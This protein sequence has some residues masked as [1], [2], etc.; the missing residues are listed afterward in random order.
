MRMTRFHPLF[1]ALALALTAP[2]PSLAEEP[3]AATPKARSTLGSFD[4]EFLFAKITVSDMVRAYRFYTEVIGLQ[5]AAPMLK[6]PAPGDPD[7]D[8]VEYPLNFT[9]SLTQP[10]LVVIRQRG[11]IPSPESARLTVVGIKVPDVAAAMARAKAAGAA[12]VREAGPGA[13]T[14]GMVTDPDGYTVE[15]I[16]GGKRP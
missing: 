14:F 6:P 9:G 7:Q 15:F 1:A 13:I 10:F 8:F 3:A 12:V 2:F 5:L 16:G 11:Q 4:S